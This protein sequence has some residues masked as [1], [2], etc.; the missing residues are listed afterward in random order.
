MFYYFMLFSFRG[1]L[2]H[3]F[4]P[5]GLSSTWN[6]LLETDY[7]CSLALLFFEALVSD[8]SDCHYFHLEPGLSRR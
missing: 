8:R 3:S 5:S 6:Y 4:S 7:Y 2:A 1:E